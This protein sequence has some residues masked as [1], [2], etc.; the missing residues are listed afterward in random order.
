MTVSYKLHIQVKFLLINSKISL[1]ICIS[2]NNLYH[3][4]SF[5]FTVKLLWSKKLNGHSTIDVISPLP[6]KTNIISLGNTGSPGSL[7]MAVESQTLF[8]DDD[9]ERLDMGTSLY[10]L[11]DGG[12][13]DLYIP[14]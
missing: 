3:E 11:S 7:L 10:K 9:G 14:E 5:I 1:F 2:F 8:S 4:K 12:V 6:R 13:G